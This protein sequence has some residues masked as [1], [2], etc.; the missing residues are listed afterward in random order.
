MVLD[1]I[2]LFAFRR[3]DGISR[4]LGAHDDLPHV[5]TG[6]N[7]HHLA[8]YIVEVALVC[9]IGIILFIHPGRYRIRLPFLIK[10]HSAVRHAHIHDFRDISICLGDLPVQ[11]LRTVAEEPLYRLFLIF[12]IIRQRL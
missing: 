3:T 10:I 5:S 2:I 9:V 11:F 4:I 12:R 6:Q 8:F 1:A 7:D